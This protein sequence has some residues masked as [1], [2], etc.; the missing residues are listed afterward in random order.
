MSSRN[1]LNL[2]LLVVVA[3]LVAV[4]V[5]DPGKKVTPVTRLTSL[6]KN[7]VHKI[8]IARPGSKTV[9]LEKNGDNWRMLK[10]YAMPANSFKADAITE[11]AQAKARA[12]YPI[13]QGEDLKPYGLMPPRLSVTF[14]DKVKLEF[15]GIETLKYLRYIRKNNTLYLIFDHFFSNIS[16]PPA[17]FVDH[18]LL[19]GHPKITKL[20]LPKL[21]LTAVG[22]KWQTQ[23]PIKN[24]SN[25]R[26]NELL[27][28]WNGAHATD[29]L[30]Y[31]PDKTGEQARVYIKGK[32]K[33]LVFDII[34]KKHMISFGRGDLGLQ[35]EFSEDVAEDML[36]LPP[37]ISNTKNKTGKGATKKQSA[38]PTTTS[39]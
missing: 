12:H 18:K 17:E 35:Y 21:T 34:R 32:D 25:D 11:L 22:D 39:R 13:K 8:E 20:V 37:K 19:T 38:A 27:D 24:L 9:V 7:D 15:G 3:V 36:K 26:V 5:I 6:A 1:L 10:P 23:P 4:V 2:V 28:N 33:P 16:N 14:N 29:V 31:T 30:A